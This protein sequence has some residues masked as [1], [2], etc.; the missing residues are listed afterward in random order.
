MKR[1]NFTAERVAGFKC[2]PSKQ[3]SIYWDGKTPGLGLRVTSTGAK[4]FIFETSLHGKTLRLTIGDVRTWAIGKAQSEATRL[5]TLTDQ[6]V[7]PR[8]QKADRAAADTD[9]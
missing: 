3:Q 5:K 1:E 2:K 9:K 7:D 4:S 6:G 8:Q